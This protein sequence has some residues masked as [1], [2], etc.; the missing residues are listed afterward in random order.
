M[1]DTWRPW[2]PPAEHMADIRCFRFPVTD[3]G[4]LSVLLHFNPALDYAAVEVDG[5]FPAVL[6]TGARHQLEFMAAGLEKAEGYTYTVK[7]PRWMDVREREL[8]LWGSS[9]FNTISLR[10]ERNR[11]LAGFGDRRGDGSRLLRSLLG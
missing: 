2:A 4:G 9:I 1:A 3:P 7:I 5:E 10:N 8:T 6:Q 11:P